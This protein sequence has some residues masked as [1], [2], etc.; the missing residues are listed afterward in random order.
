MPRRCSD[1]P[2]GATHF[3]SGWRA[4]STA[5]SA[6]E[7]KPL[8]TTSETPSRR[9]AACMRSK[10]AATSGRIGLPWRCSSGPRYSPGPADQSATS[11]GGAS[12]ASARAPARTRSRAPTSIA[13]R[14]STRTRTGANVSSSGNDT[15]IRARRCCAPWRARHDGHAR[16]TRRA[17]HGRG[18]GARRSGAARTTRRRP[19]A[20]HARQ[21]AHRDPPLAARRSGRRCPAR[22]R[23]GRGRRGGPRAR[24]RAG[25]SWPGRPPSGRR[26]AAAAGWPGSARPPMRSSTAWRGVVGAIGRR[27]RT[28][29]RSGRRASDA[30]TAAARGRRQRGCVPDRPAESRTSARA[31]VRRWQGARAPAPRRRNRHDDEVLHRE[32]LVERRG[33]RP[34][35]CEHRRCGAGGRTDSQRL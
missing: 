20:W 32:Q 17:R 22:S 23:P 5:C 14:T 1:R 16:G 24:C 9:A 6:F 10:A 29:R 19:R 30:S 26:R 18:W 27:I 28:A 33:T 7:R 21:P 15:P 11:A 13:S 34:G 35:Q 25:G 2:G 4:N 12:S 8:T 3:G 31:A